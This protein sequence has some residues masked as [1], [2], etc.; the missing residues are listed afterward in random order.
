VKYSP[1]NKV[2]WKYCCSLSLFLVSTGRIGNV[3]EEE[4]LKTE[5]FTLTAYNKCVSDSDIFYNIKNLESNFG[6]SLNK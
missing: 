4:N 6:I 3:P 2:T 5:G 1:V